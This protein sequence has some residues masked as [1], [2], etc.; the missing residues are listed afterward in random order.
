MYQVYKI[1]KFDAK[2]NGYSIG[3][4]EENWAEK[5]DCE[6]DNLEEAKQYVIV[7]NRQQS[8]LPLFLI[9]LSDSEKKE[10]IEKFCFSNEP[11]WVCK[12]RYFLGKI[13]KDLVY[14]GLRSDGCIV[15]SK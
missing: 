5:F 13:N 15:K 9:T 8:D 10:F 2:S 11:T 14:E 4:R 12:R 6:F 1:E 7:K 3:I